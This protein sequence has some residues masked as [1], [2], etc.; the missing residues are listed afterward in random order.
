MNGSSTAVTRSSGATWLGALGR[1]LPQGSALPEEVWARRHRGILILLWLHVPALF[2]FALF[3]GESALHATQET[4]I[5]VVLAA[6]ASL[7]WARRRL[8]TVAAA[9]GLLTCSAVLVHLSGGLIEMH[10]H[11]FVMVGVVTLYQ[12]WWPF[13]TAIGYV[14]VEHGVAGALSPEDVFNHPAAVSHP[15]R[16]AAVHGVF[17][18]GMSAAGIISWKLNESLLIAVGSR[19]QRLAEAQQVARLGSW[20][21]DLD[22]GTVTWSDEM[23]RLGGSEPQSFQPSPDTV[24]SRVHPDDRPVVDAAMK[25]TIEEGIPGKVDFRVVADDGPRW[26]HGRWEAVGWVDGRPSVIAGTTQDVTDRREAEGAMRD[27]EERFRAVTETA[28]DAI[29]IADGGDGRVVSLN[30][31]A[32]KLFGVTLDDVVGR[33]FRS[34]VPEHVTTSNLVGT[35]RT[36]EVTGVRADGTVFPLELS[37]GTFVA[38]GTAFVT[39]IM[40]DITERKRAEGELRETLSLLEAT[41]DSTADGI[42]VVD[43][44][45]KI[46]S[47]NRQFA[48]MWRLPKA[49]LDTRDDDAALTYALAQVLDPDAFVAKVRELYA[50]PFAESHDTI[51]FHDGRFFERYSKPQLV[52]GAIVGRV[53]SFRDVT[54]RKRLE[55]ELAHQ[56][57]HDPLTDLAN[58]ALFRDRVEHALAR[59]TRSGNEVAVVFVDLDHFKTVN[60]SLGHTA[61]DELLTTVASRIDEAVREDDTAARLGGDEFAVLIEDVTDRD[62]V[63]V[64]VDRILEAIKRP[65]TLGGKEVAVT[66][67]IGVAFDVAGTTVDKLLA[68]ADLAMYTAK[69]AGRNRYETF[70]PDMHAA[71]VEY[72]DLANDLRRACE[73]GEIVLHY[74]PIVSLPDD[75]MVGVE[76]LVRWEHPTRG[77]LGPDAFI[78]LAE[79]TGLVVQLG[80]LVLHETCRQLRAWDDAGLTLSGSVNLSA[81]QLADPGLVADVAD[82]LS[83]YGIAPERLSLELTESA[84]M[85]H[86]ERN[87]AALHQLKAVGVRLAVDDFGT[88]YSSLSYLRHFPIDSLKIDR[89]FVSDIPAGAVERSLAQAIVT[90]ARNLGLTAVAEGVE[91]GAQA[92]VLRNLGCGFAQGYHYS[93]AVPAD[94]ITRIALDSSSIRSG[95]Q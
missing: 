44:E 37:M 24:L 49:L 45:G 78:P 15:W 41:L 80:R 88:G 40:R 17:I 66:A 52:A 87:V 33:P 13:L 39:G 68:N 16:W 27:S 82:T 31:Q 30:S 2:V 57:F 53:W 61:G 20:E 72:L 5:V 19:E 69:A 43:A 86:T 3:V 56:A 90:V 11:F 77:L 42:L 67:S 93:P 94:G 4:G 48:E 70:E 10:F 81:L 74:Q 47:F 73:R 75:R 62:D 84:L 91:T 95:R 59:A 8:S 55:D 21:W 29:V 85:E 54:E 12:E 22:A 34:L 89:S 76:A 50:Q 1:Y 23:F 6:A 26:V 38:G 32:L 14:V 36:L 51:A 46:T 25:A 9:I 79:Q 83:T 7:S 18:L 92:D 65:T 63:L 64:I 58:K 71:A 28:S 60:D 35:G